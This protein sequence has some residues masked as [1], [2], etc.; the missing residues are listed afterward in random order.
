MLQSE[1][2]CQCSWVAILTPDPRFLAQSREFWANVR[3]IS[4]EVGYTRRGH[5]TIKVPTLGEIRAAFLPLT[6]TTSHI[7]SST[8]EL[9]PLGDSLL[10]YFAFRAGMLNDT[11][12]HQLMDKVAAE[13]EFSRLK[14]TLKPTCPLPRNK[15]KGEKQNYSFLTGIVNM[16]V[17]AGTADIGCDFDPRSLTTITHDSMPLRTLARRVDG[18]FP[19]V[20]F[21]NPEET[22]AIDLALAAARQRGADLVIANDPDADRC[23]VAVPD[24]NAGPAGGWRM[25]TGDELG[26]LLG[27]HLLATRGWADPIVACSIVSSQLLARIAAA[28]GARHEQTLT[29]FKWISRVPGLRFGYEEALGYC[30]A[31]EV[32]RDKDGISAALI[33]CELAASLKAQGRTLLDALDDLALT[34]GL[35]AT[36]PLSFRVADL[37]L[38][39]AAMTRLRAHPLTSLGGQA[40]AGVDDLA[41]PAPAPATAMAMA[42]GVPATGGALPPTEGLRYR[43]D[44]GIRVVV[45][46]SG[47]EP[48]LKCYLEVVV[49]VS[50]GRPGLPGARRRAEEL[51]SA[52]RADLSAALA[53]G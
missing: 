27:E 19:T 46:P 18:A 28:H 52:V 3:T 39:S 33:V 36:S 30:V 50:G 1:F 51:L 45:R 4:Q 40:V 21:P 42:D 26:A 17:E 12:Q 53:L 35:H 32:V 44:G 43:A 22:G 14:R 25:L 9:T 37:S 38:I 6:L 2:H 11:V 23:A 16:L 5:G 7:A 24:S 49:P 31:P 34:H 47:T 10:A 41:A 20:A 13:V 29:G 8:D 48:K 15:Q